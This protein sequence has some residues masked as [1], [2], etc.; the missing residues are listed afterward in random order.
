MTSYDWATKI[1]TLHTTD[2]RSPSEHA[3]GKR[4]DFHKSFGTGFDKQPEKGGFH[5][6]AAR[7]YLLDLCRMF[8]CDWV[9][10]CDDDEFYMPGA[11]DAICAAHSTNKNVVWFSCY[12]FRSPTHYLWWPNQVRRVHRAKYPM[13]DAHPRAFRMSLNWKYVVNNNEKYRNELNNRTQHCHI[14]SHPSAAVLHG[15]GKHHIHTR[16]MFDPKRPTRDWLDA[17]ENRES[18]IVL[19]SVI[20]NAWNK[21]ESHQH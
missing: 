16:H 3:D 1:V 19:P 15:Y 4:Y 11:Y 14:N 8:G 6:V 18:D 17:R 9:L 10:I 12:H 20:L 2:N 5:E 13:H 7:N 21:Q